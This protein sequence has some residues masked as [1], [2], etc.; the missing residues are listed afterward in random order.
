MILYPV[1]D[2][3]HAR[4]SGSAW[5]LTGERVLITGATGFLGSWM[6]QTLDYQCLI[7]ESR[8]LVDGVYDTI[9]CFAPTPIEPVIECAQKSGALVV[10]A[11][12]GAVYGGVEK[13]VSEDDAVQPKT[14]YGKEKA[15]GEQLLIESG[16]D[17]QI[18]RLFTL[19]GQ[20]MRNHF[21]LTH[22]ID[23]VKH[24][25]SMEVFGNGQTVR[26]Y[27]Y[28]AD[29]IG[30][31]LRLLNAPHGI[32]NIGSE[33]PITINALAEEISY[34]THGH[35]YKYTQPDWIEPAPFYLPSCRKA[36]NYGCYQKF[37]LDHILKRML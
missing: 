3:N 22:F 4:R 8:D 5:L 19:A 21:A 29:V 1:D 35:P 34:Y 27:L 20:G 23:A 31:M 15:R 25:D 10:Y 26:S 14:L 16:V 30:W 37:G 2:I 32:Y 13:Q 6:K 9:F 36:R 11:S 28:A 12:S 7:T 33:I 24:G 17:Y 18:Y